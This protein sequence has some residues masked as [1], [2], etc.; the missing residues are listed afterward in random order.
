MKTNICS[1]ALITKMISRNQSL[2]R[3][4]AQLGPSLFSIEMVQYFPKM[5]ASLSALPHYLPEYFT[6]GFSSSN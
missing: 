2:S 3:S 4:L 1:F 5:A 6:F